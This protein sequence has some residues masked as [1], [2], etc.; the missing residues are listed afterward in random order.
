MTQP[1]YGSYVIGRWWFFVVLNGSEYTISRAFD[2]TLPDGVAAIFRALLE[3]KVYISALF[4]E[5]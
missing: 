1:V 5:L 2:C 3:V 4:A